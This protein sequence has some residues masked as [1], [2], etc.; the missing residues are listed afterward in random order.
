MKIKEA[1]I[2]T[3]NSL[4]E[5]YDKNEARSIAQLIFEDLGT[6]HL[7]IFTS[8][9]TILSSEKQVKLDSIVSEALDNKPIQHILGYAWFYER[10]FL[11][12]PACLIP[13]Q[14]TEQMVDLVIKEKKKF[15]Y[16]LDIGTGSGCI[17]ISLKMALENSDV[18]GMD[19]SVKALEVAKQNAS[20]HNTNVNFIIDDIF[21]PEFSAYPESLDL[22]VSNPPYIRE[23][24]KAFMNENVFAFEPWEA[25]FVKDSD[26]LVFCSAIRNFCDQKLSPGGLIFLEINEA[27]AFETASIFNHDKRYSTFIL[28]DIH[29]K[30]RIIKSIRND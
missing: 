4:E 6:K 27:L 18:A 30:N 9:D 21:N 5:I 1:Y 14:E 22:V 7:D 23:S 19:R 17:A 24:E 2:K 20:L 13:R 12:S 8:P 16:I 15:K 11:V 26:P 29:G 28:K 3:L 10:K 25:L